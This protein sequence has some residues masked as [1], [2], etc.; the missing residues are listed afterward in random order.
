MIEI[1][2]KDVENKFRYL[3]KLKENKYE[4]LPVEAVVVEVKPALK[5]AKAILVKEK[6]ESNSNTMDV[7]KKPKSPS[8]ASFR[9]SLLKSNL[10]KKSEDFEVVIN[11]PNPNPP[12]IVQLVAPSTP[13]ASITPQKPGTAVMDA[14]PEENENENSSKPQPP[15][16]AD[17]NKYKM[18][19]IG[20]NGE[21]HPL[22]DTQ[23]ECQMQ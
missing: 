8:F 20:P 3:E 23:L 7:V 22:N 9:S 2:V 16:P 19:F 21:R 15:L 18:V 12:P 11:V 1:Q 13:Q 17:K 5:R 10:A 6:A 4:P 14:M